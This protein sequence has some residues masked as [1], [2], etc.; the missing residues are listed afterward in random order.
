MGLALGATVNALLPWPQR[1]AVLAVVVVLSAMSFG[2]FWS[3]AMSMLTQTGETIGLDHAF[4][5]AL[6]NLAWAP[7]QALGSAVGGSLA[8]STSDAVPYLL[9]SALCLLTLAGIQAS[10][11]RGAAAATLRP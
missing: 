9:L 2:M 4:A 6:V 3:P 11:R 10:T 7:G 1:G 5:F 8:R